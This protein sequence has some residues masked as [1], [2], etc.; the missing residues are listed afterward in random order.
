ME[1]RVHAY[2]QDY[3]KISQESHQVNG[4]EEAE[5]ERL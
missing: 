4:Q 3:E 2:S 5:D 1:V